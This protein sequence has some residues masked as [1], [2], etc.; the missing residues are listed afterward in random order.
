M[1]TRFCSRADVAL[2]LLVVNTK[3]SPPRLRKASSRT[4]RKAAA[5]SIFTTDQLARRL[6]PPALSLLRQ[7]PFPSQLEMMEEIVCPAVALR[8]LPGEQ[9]QQGSF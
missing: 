1:P 3:P 9:L 6:S 8:L 4:P 2:R 7:L 5:L